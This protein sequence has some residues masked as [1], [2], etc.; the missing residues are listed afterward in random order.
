MIQYMENEKMMKICV[1][2]KHVPDTAVAIRVVGDAGFD[3][4][5]KHVMNPYDEYALEEAVRLKEA[6]GGEVVVICVGKAAAAAT[7]RAAMAFG[8]DRGILVKTETAFQDS[9]LTASVLKTVI[10][11]EGGADLIFMGKQSVD[12]EGMQTH[13]R[14]GAALGIPV[15]NEVIS[16]KMDGERA[17]VQREISG[18][19]REVLEMTLPCVIG[20]TKGLNEPRYPKLRGIMEAKKKPLRELDFAEMGI[21]QPD[22]AVELTRLEP[23]PERGAAT[24]LEGSVGEMVAELVNRLRNEAK[25]I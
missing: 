16:F 23:I 6:V 5:V 2:V 24:M 13:Y 1:C 14:L 12:T 18:G 9:A 11:Q 22:G 17:V 21:E 15:A 19:D 4:S 3:E 20:A 25:V 8:A 7:A 10:S